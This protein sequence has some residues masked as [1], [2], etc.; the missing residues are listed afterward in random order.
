MCCPDGSKLLRRVPGRNTTRGWGI[1]TWG[2]HARVH[3]GMHVQGTPV[4]EENIGVVYDG[5]HDAIHAVPE[6]RIGSWGMMDTRLRSMLSPTAAM[7]KPSILISP[8]CSGS[9]IRNRATRTEDFPAPVR[10]TI[11]TLCPGCTVKE[12]PHSTGS[13]PVATQE[14]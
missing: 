7:L 1:C 12:S 2:E 6:K 5:M 3:D 4:P 14:I 8:A 11:P 9:A 10:P 13:R